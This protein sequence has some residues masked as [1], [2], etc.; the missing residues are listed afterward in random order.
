MHHSDPSCARHG[1]DPWQVDISAAVIRGFE[2]LGW[3]TG[4]HWPVP[5]RLDSHRRDR[6]Q[7]RPRPVLQH[8]KGLLWMSRRRTRH[9]R[10]VTPPTSMMPSLP[11]T[12][13]RLCTVL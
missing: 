1:A 5:A 3:A 4:V 10:A 2:R 12:A 9:A 11:A 8:S 13:R 6:R 7:A